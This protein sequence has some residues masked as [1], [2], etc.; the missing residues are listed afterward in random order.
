M[1]V[2]QNPVVMDGAVGK[3][4]KSNTAPS[5]SKT[6]AIEHGE[7]DL[8]HEENVDTVLAAKMTLINDVSIQEYLCLS[9]CNPERN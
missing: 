7:H 3:D 5:L 1:D 6:E 8:L 4:E 2:E 9:P